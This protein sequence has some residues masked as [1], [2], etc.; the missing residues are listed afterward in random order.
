VEWFSLLVVE[1]VEEINAMLIHLRTIKKFSQGQITPTQMEFL[2]HKHR[3]HA[4]ILK[5]SVGD[6][7][8]NPDPRVSGPSGS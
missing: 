6:P 7:D 8:P 2:N 4:V 1:W 3:E 5:F